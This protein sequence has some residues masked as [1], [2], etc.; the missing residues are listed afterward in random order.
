MTRPHRPTA[1]ETIGL[2]LTE[3]LSNIARD[4]RGEN[5]I[6]AE[7]Q[8]QEY[9]GYI[10]TYD[11]PPIP[12]RSCDWQFYHEDFDGAPDA[13]DYR[14]G[15]ARTAQE[16]RDEIDALISDDEVDPDFE[17]RF[18]AEEKANQAD[19]EIYEAR[20]DTGD[21][22]EDTEEQETFE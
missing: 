8:R 3:A 19:R 4:V 12:T 2:G 11:P 17:A 22:W 7:P 16:C 18:R 13:F 5:L 10:I 1:L 15:F 9:R 14:S 20:A 6:E 21:E